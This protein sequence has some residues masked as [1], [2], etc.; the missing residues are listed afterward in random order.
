M[1]WYRGN[2]SSFA[3]ASATATLTLLFLFGLS[4]SVVIYRLFFN[5]LNRFPGPLAARLSKLYYV[6]LSSNLLGH[7]ELHKLH[8][9]YGRYVRIGPNDLSVVDPDGMKI[10]LGANSKCTK[11]A[12]YGQDMPYIS[13]NTTRDRATHDRRR[14][15]L[16]PAFN[17]K[18]LQ[19]YAMR[20]Q[21]FHSQLTSQI[22]AS[23]GKPMDVTKWFGFWGMDMMCD[24]V[25]NGSFNMLES[26]ETHWALKVL[27]DGLHLQGLALPPWLYRVFATM[28]SAGSGSRGLADFAA[29]QLDNRMKQQGKTTHPDIMQPL[30]EHY[31]RLHP[32]AKKAIL[33]MLQG[34]SRMLIIAGSDTTSTTLT[35]M[36]YRFCSEKGLVQRLREELAPL[37]ADVHNISY[38]DVRQAQLLHGC[39]NETL[40]MHY[41]GPSGFFRKTPRE[42]IHIGEVYIPGDTIIQ[43]PPYVMAQ[44]ETIY[45][46]C[47]EFVPERWYS[48]PEM[49][50]HKD[51]FMPFLAGSESCI[52]KHLA[53][54]Q[55]AV[56]ST[57]ILLQFD[58]VFAPGEDGTKLIQGS[59]DLGIL[60]PDELSLVFA[61]RSKTV[62]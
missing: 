11:S 62:A 14:R 13:T 57:Q 36:F 16:S 43:L 47:Q 41:P 51:A 27:G 39:I 9:K 50:K 1:K 42:G 22:D 30:I 15:I 49:V 52:G 46:R 61:R 59:K 24:I 28:P 12:W 34:D 4:S 25:F 45:E 31:Q 44:D 53:Y 54:I 56:V 17:D 20:I 3:A 26:G 6:H 38:Q 40:R 60:H 48:R 7:Q 18:A 58:V 23:A 2:L 5:P 29:T 21:K 37:V 8:Q 32:Q 33:P 19:G 10:V 35:H 55:L